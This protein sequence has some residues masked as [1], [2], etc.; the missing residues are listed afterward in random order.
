MKRCT[1]CCLRYALSCIAE[2]TADGPAVSNE[3]FQVFCSAA[4]RAIGVPFSEARLQ[5]HTRGQQFLSTQHMLSFIDR[6]L[7]Y[8]RRRARD[9]VLLE[10]FC[11][12]TQM[13][14]ELNQRRLHWPIVGPTG[15]LAF[16]FWRVFATASDG[17]RTVSSSKAAWMQCRLRSELQPTHL[18]PSRASLSVASRGR[19]SYWQLLEVVASSLN[20][21]SEAEEDRHLQT[22]HAMQLEVENRVIMQGQLEKRGNIRRNWNQRCFVLLPGLLECYSNS[23]L[24][25]LKGTCHITPGS[26]VK[27]VKGESTRDFRFTV[28]CGRTGKVF[29]MSAANEEDRKLWVAHIRFVIQHQ[30]VTSMEHFT[31]IERDRTALFELSQSIMGLARLSLEES[32]LNSSHMFTDLI[33]RAKRFFFQQ[34]A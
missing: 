25:T 12:D 1:Q 34:E 27:C 19:L 8:S 13:K 18:S 29:E 23:S 22:V 15:E 2:E 9:S 26:L 7:L 17:D 4:S 14:A 21:T 20:V 24:H 5:E 10:R 6:H 30:G 11:W 33:C 3:S 16:Q 28:S 31:A 32:L